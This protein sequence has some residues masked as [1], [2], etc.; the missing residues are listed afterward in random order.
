MSATLRLSRRRFLQVLAGAAGALVVGVRFAE[1][2]DT[3]TPVELL[4]DVYSQIGPFVRIE[5]DGRVIIGARTPDMGQGTRTALPRI[6]AEELDADWAQVT[7]LGLPLGVEDDGGKP[8][9][10]YGD[11][12]AGG[13]TSV[14]QA[15]QDLRQAGAAARW[16]LVQAAARRWNVPA[17]R[18]RTE[19]GAVIAPDGRRA[20][21]GDLAADAARIDLPKQPLPLKNPAQYRL[22]G[23]PAG[24]V[25]AHGIVT[26]TLQ[27]AID[28]GFAEALVAVIARCPYL[29]GSLAEVDDSEALKVP[30]VV[31]V[32]PLPGP[33]PALP[34]GE[35][36]LAPGVAVL[37]EDTWAALQGRD[38]LKL[39]WKPGKWADESTAA[40]ER[41]ALDKLAGAPTMRARDDGDF[42][43]FFKL[44]RKLQADYYVP[45]AAHAT[46]EPMNC[47]ARVEE[48]RA[49]V[50][51]PTQ[52]P[53]RAFEVVRRITGLSP[54]QIDIRFPRIGG[55][56]GRRLEDDYVAEA[57]LLAKSVGK[58]VKV[59]WTREDDMTHDVYRPCGVHRM[60]AATDRRRRI[61]A[62]RHQLASA[63]KRNGAGGADQQ[64][65]SEI[66]PDDLP[67]G[68]VANLRYDWY[69]LDSGVKRGNW[70][71][72][73]HVSNAF[74]VQSFIDEIAAAL[75]VD[76]LKFRLDLLGAPRRLP[77]RSHG[78]PVLDTGRLANVLKLAAERIGW[79]Q[80]RT[81]GHGLGIACHFTFGGYAAHAFEVSVEGERLL[82]HRAVCAVDVGR[83]INPL[84]VEAQMMGGTIDGLSTA[85]N[86]AIT[87]KD[88]QVQQK[89]FPDYPL[90][91]MAAMPRAVEVQIVESDADP[92][93]AG[94][95]GIP[96]VAP[97]LANAVYAA[98]T[99]RVRRLPL[100]PELLRL[101]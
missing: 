11:Q 79:G 9:F 91:R 74:A 46:M 47:L 6:I 19:A 44:G 27:F 30:G 61:I 52:T 3:G 70:R 50:V 24:N 42:D 29:D 53:D 56:F 43:K 41:Q 57:V 94:E 23:K 15:W 65:K 89:N 22:V 83:A 39:A 20:G 16:L 40:L 58:P 67:A 26:G 38:R 60:S 21:Y 31:K 2:Q 10:I 17:E 33:D 77:Y 86:L 64:W 48:D 37:A 8:R 45:Y 66:H 69:A 92:A 99:V 34:I 1:A 12:S 51:A 85:L 75:K 80:R 54:A 13:S 68:L 101:L 93:G 18:L 5:P 35:Q 90:A 7:V 96:S 82:I 32:L 100:L 28:H 95:I 62:W 63:S 78:G 55:G 4:G 98:T 59:M 84:G 87:V 72:P 25:D 97:A 76:P 88:G 71:A 49:V 36:P 81:N 14:P 73:A